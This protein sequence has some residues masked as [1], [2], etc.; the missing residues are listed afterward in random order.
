MS[1]DK[2]FDDMTPEELMNIARH[3]TKKKKPDQAL[4]Q[5]HRFVL[6]KNLRPGKL[7]VRGAFIYELYKEWMGRDNR[8]IQSKAKFFRDFGKLFERIRSMSYTYYLIDED[9]IELPNELEEEKF[10]EITKK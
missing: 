2:K 10:R 1:V 4:T 6:A 7:K 3:K 5:A 9:T 8:N